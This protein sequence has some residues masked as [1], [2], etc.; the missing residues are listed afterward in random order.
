M[1]LDD[2]RF[3]VWE[4]LKEYE[5]NGCLPKAIKIIYKGIKASVRVNGQL[6]NMFLSS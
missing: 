2:Q 6:S 4:V 5:V 3:E 1:I